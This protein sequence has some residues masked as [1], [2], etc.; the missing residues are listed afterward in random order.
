M[1]FTVAILVAACAMLTNAVAVP[2][3][4]SVVCYAPADQCT[5]A[6]HCTL[7]CNYAGTPEGALPFY[8]N[9]VCVGY[10]LH[11]YSQS[12]LPKSN[13][14]SRAPGKPVCKA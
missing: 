3:T 7:V 8:R 2:Q 13:L 12:T 10:A 9:G 1:R 11:N 6:N 14:Q 4:I 5:K